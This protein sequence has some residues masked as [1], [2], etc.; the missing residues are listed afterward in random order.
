MIT[1]DDYYNMLIK[2][3]I[4]KPCSFASF[5]SVVGISF[6]DSITSASA[7]LRST[8]TKHK[9]LKRTNYIQT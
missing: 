8:N 2:C 7:G 1:N 3:H 6:S 9:Q 4:L 5:A